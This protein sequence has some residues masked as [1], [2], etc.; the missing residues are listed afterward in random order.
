MAAVP[1]AI[2]LIGALGRGVVVRRRVTALLGERSHTCPGTERPVQWKPHSS[3]QWAS[4]S[5]DVSRGSKETVAVWA[6]GFASTAST[7]R[8]RP[9]TRSTTSFSLA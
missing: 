9:S 3:T 5:I 1:V 7:P 4:S 2:R 6:T 8:R